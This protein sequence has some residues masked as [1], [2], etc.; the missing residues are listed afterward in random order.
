MGWK[1]LPGGDPFVEDASPRPTGDPW[2]RGEDAP[3]PGLLAVPRGLGAAWTLVLVA[4]AMAAVLA[5]GL[6]WSGLIV[7]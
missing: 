5:V 1:A 7:G 3:D 6:I 2:S 4:L